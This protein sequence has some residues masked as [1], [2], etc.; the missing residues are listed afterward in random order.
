MRVRNFG[1]GA[2]FGALE[3]SRNPQRVTVGDVLPLYL[4]SAREALLLQR[5]RRTVPGAAMPYARLL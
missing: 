5:W 2:A 4:G 3:L 1:K